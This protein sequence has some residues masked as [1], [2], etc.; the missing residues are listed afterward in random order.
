MICSASFAILIT[1]LFTDAMS[2]HPNIKG[3]SSSIIASTRTILVT[4][5]IALAGYFFNGTIIPLTAIIT[6][7]LSLTIII[8]I[9]IIHPKRG[10]VANGSV[11][12]KK[13][14]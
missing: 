13:V 14:W 10:S 8:Y 12:L 3:A 7:L 11:K 5:S 1:I 2:L 6:I 4:I 9:F